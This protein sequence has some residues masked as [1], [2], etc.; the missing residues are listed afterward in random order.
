MSI[1]SSVSHF[2]GSCNAKLIEYCLTKNFWVFNNEEQLCL[3]ADTNLCKVP[4]NWCGL[5]EHSNTKYH[6]NVNIHMFTLHTHIYIQDTKQHQSNH[7][8]TNLPD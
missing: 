6:T 2:G 8:G 7:L 5:L 3:S 4:Q 1:L